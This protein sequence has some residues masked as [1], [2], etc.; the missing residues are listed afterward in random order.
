MVMTAVSGKALRKEKRN[1]VLTTN[2]EQITFFKK[3]YW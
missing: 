2:K 1:T 3:I